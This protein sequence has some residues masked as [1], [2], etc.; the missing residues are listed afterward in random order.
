[1]ISFSDLC[2][3]EV[4]NLCDGKRLGYV[5]D[6]EIDTECGR[7]IRI[8]IPA[9]NGLF[10]GKARIYIKWNSIERI[11]EDT[12]LVRYTEIQTNK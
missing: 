3:K 7:I 4:I 6:A 12:V 2:E 8:A 11:G 9:K 10:V 5:C 1:M